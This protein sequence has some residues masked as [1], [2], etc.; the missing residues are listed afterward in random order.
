ML[1]L[2]C[3]LLLIGFA[4]GCGSDEPVVQPPVV[5]PS[6]G[7]IGVYGD[8][9]GTIENVVD[10]GGAVT[11]YVVHTVEDGA[12]ASTFRVEAPAGWTRL[13]VESQF[14]VTIGDVDEGISIAYG[15]CAKGT[16]HLMTLTYESPG[17]TQ[18]G[19]MFK[20]LPHTLWPDHIQVVDCDNNVLENARGAESPVVLPQEADGIQDPSGKRPATDE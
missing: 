15:N 9:D 11:L 7:T 20:V 17:D 3:I 10:F 2:F 6:A 13:A 18:A 5:T 8:A 1:Q 16:I 12:T 19:A 14:P 4:A